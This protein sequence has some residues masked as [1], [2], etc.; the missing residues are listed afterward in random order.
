M[1]APWALFATWY[2]GSP[3][4][5]SLAAKTLA[6][7]LEPSAGTIRL[8][9]QLATPFFEDQAFGIPSIAVGLVLY[10]LLSLL[11]ARAML[12][13]DS[14]AWVVSLY[15][16]LYGL[17]FAVANPLIF[18]WY[19][20]PPLPFYFLGLM[21]GLNALV[22]DL[23]RALPIRAPARV[24]AGALA[25]PLIG[26][27][28]LSLNAWTLHPDHGPQQPA[29][30]MAWHLLELYYTD[31]GRSLAAQVT[32]TT[33]IA[34]GD[35]GALGYYSNAR[36]LD[37]V[38]LMSPEA[39]RYFP[40]PASDYVINYAMP[41]QLIDDAAPDYVV[42]LEVYGREGLL[43]DSAFLQDYTLQERVD[44]D[45]YGSDGLLIYHRVAP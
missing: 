24:A 1:L 5:H 19:L 38:G 15:P 26:A 14:R 10:P 20:A 12:R 40:L 37:T 18:R 31:G 42:L 43:R 28:A 17:A 13:R 8:L 33:V 30:A 11:G 3:I 6:Y 16:W 2:F 29:P 39:S 34:A 9:Q 32:P 22:H 44:T 36:I 21:A 4:P 45:I 7:R 27:L 23:I 35:V 25:V 41:P